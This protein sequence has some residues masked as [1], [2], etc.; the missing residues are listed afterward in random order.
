MSK[1]NLSFKNGTHMYLKIFS[2]LVYSIVGKIT[3]DL[4]KIVGYKKEQILKRLYIKVKYCM[5][6]TVRTV[7]LYVIYKLTKL[8]SDSSKLDSEFKFV[9]SA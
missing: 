2:K 3:K 7:Y 4:K 5:Y 6:C 9:S 1:I 8:D